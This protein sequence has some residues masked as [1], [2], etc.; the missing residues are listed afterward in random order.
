MASASDK[1]N[2]TRLARDSRDIFCFFEYVNQRYDIFGI[3]LLKNNISDSIR[4]KQNWLAQLD[5][6]D[7]VCN[8]HGQAL[9]IHDILY[10]TLLQQWYAM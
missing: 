2:L 1:G 7:S 6:L 8:R 5:Y 4:D 9:P 3:L 10:V